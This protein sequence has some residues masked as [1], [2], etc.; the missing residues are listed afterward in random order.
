MGKSL[1]VVLIDH[2]PLNEDCGPHVRFD[3]SFFAQRLEFVNESSVGF[4]QHLFTDFK[5][6]VLPRGVLSGPERSLSLLD[7]IVNFLLW[8]IGVR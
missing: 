4:D 1:E 8:L 7:L 3:R 6:P 2:S 5:Y